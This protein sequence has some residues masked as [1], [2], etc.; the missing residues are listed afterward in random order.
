MERGKCYG[1]GQFNGGRMIM[2]ERWSVSWVENNVMETGLME[3]VCSCYIGCQFNG[4][5][6]LQKWSL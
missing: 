6:M 5:R 4:G 2:L 3:A 1:Y